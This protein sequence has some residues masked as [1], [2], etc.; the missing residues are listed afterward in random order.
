MEQNA[1]AIE[2]GLGFK[3]TWQNLPKN[4]QCKIYAQHDADV[5]NKELR[6]QQFAWLK[7]T[8]ESFKSVFDPYLLSLDAPEDEAGPTGDSPPFSSI[9]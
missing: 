8:L 4:K 1:A 6:S 9:T 2:R 5:S 3:A 7:G